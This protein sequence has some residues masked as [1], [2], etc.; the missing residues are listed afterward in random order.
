VTTKK[1]ALT[2]ILSMFGYIPVTRDEL[3][4]R[5][6]HKGYGVVDK[7]IGIYGDHRITKGMTEIIT[8]MAQLVPSFERASEAIKKLI[9]IEVS[10]KQIQIVSEEV[11]REI[12]EKD[13]V[14]S[15][16]AFQKPEKTAPQELIA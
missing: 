11:G 9:K 8:Y 14:E 4:C 7:I 1:N 3:F 13:K 6:C 2:R 16:E 10:T 15:E 5:R 12:F